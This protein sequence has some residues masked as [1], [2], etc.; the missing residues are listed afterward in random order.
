[1]AAPDEVLVIA[2]I[3]ERKR[4]LDILR[5]HEQA[6]RAR[7]LTRVM[8]FGSIARVMWRQAATSIC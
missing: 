7:G 3:D 1:M 4:V 8:I 5:R 2:A 6:L